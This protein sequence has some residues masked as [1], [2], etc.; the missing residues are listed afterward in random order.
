LTTLGHEARERA[1]AQV[2]ELLA[3]YSQWPFARRSG[4]SQGVGA[5][6]GQVISDEVNGSKDKE[7]Q[8]EVRAYSSLSQTKT[9]A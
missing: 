1:F 2:D 8:L 3:E 4:G 9:D 6:L 5:N 7:L